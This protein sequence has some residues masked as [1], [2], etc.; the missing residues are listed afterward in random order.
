LGSDRIRSC[1]SYP[2]ADPRAHKKDG[3][4]EIDFALKDFFGSRS[5]CYKDLTSKSQIG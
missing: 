3:A 4:S 1:R 2:T 5:D